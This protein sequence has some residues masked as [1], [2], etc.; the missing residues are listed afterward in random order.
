MSDEI[1]VRIPVGSRISLLHVAQTGPGAHPISYPVGTS[2]LKSLVQKP[3]PQNLQIFTSQYAALTFLFAN[4]RTSTLTPMHLQLN[5][6][7]HI[8]LLKNV[9]LWNELLHNMYVHEPREFITT[10]NY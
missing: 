5:P 4:V 3:E 2:A 7:A 10:K 1:R 6:E 9:S 8:T